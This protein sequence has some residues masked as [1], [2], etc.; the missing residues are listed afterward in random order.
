MTPK[1]KDARALSAQRALDARN[2]SEA[3][4]AIYGFFTNPRWFAVEGFKFPS[5]RGSKYVTDRWGNRV[6]ARP[7]AHHGE[8][9]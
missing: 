1:R 6:L 3:L 7:E 8:N 2:R 5:F 9:A 4:Q